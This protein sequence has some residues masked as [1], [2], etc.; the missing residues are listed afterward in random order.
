MPQSI[1]DQGAGLA[2]KEDAPLH[3]CALSAAIQRTSE[4]LFGGRCPRSHSAKLARTARWQRCRRNINPLNPAWA[5]NGLTRRTRSPDDGPGRPLSDHFS[6]GSAAG[7][8]RKGQRFKQNKSRP[9]SIPSHVCVRPGPESR[10]PLRLKRVKQKALRLHVCSGQAL[11][12]P[13]RAV[14]LW[15]GCCWPAPRPGRASVI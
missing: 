4:D 6:S 2:D 1:S 11:H 7:R 14:R 12:G 5:A 13:G 9:A 8:G 3:Q 10:R 15:G